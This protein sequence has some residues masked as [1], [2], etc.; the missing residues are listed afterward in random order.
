MLNNSLTSKIALIIV[1]ILFSTIILAQK[2]QTDLDFYI[3]LIQNNYLDEAKYIDQ[4]KLIENSTFFKKDSFLWWKANLF[5][6]LSQFDSAAFYLSKVTVNSQL[7]P[8]SKFKAS[9]FYSTNKN[10]NL[11]IKELSQIQSQNSE[12][13]TLKSTHLASTYL[14]NKDY[15]KFEKTIINIDTNFYATKEAISSI[16]FINDDI[17]ANKQKSALLAATLSTILPGSGKFY[18]GKT[19]ESMAVL[20]SVGALA[21]L[22]YENASKYDFRHTR[23]Y[24]SAS[25]FGVFYLGNII[26]SYYT[27]NRQNISFNEKVEKNILYHIQHSTHILFN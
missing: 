17:K 25:V 21:A 10:Y 6:K 27:I 3:Y 23:T 9:F 16:V 11:A 15:Q 24:L 8:Q 12:I 19:G 7:Y 2:K 5:E 1:G 20:L 14:L 13:N 26:G 22:L 4:N 18:A